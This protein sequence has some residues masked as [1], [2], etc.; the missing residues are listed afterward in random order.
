MNNKSRT[1]RSMKKVLIVAYY[2]PH[3][4]AIGSMRPLGFC[5]Y[6]DR[7]GWQPRVLTTEPISVYPAMGVDK[8]LWAQL[9]KTVRV[10]RVP[11]KNPER[12]LLQVRNKF[13]ELFHNCYSLEGSQLQAVTNGHTLERTEGRK[14]Y[15]NIKQTMIDWLLSFPDPQCYWLRPA[16]RSLS[17]VPRIEY[18]DVVFATGAPWTA[19]FV[20]KA[21]AQRFKVPLVADFRDP[22]TGNVEIR[23]P[24]LFQRATLL[25]RSIYEAA[26]CVI[27]NTDEF[28]TKLLADHPDLEKKFVMITNGFDSDPSNSVVNGWKNQEAASAV[29]VLELCHFGSVYSNRNPFFLLQAVKELVDENRIGSDHLRLRFVGGWEIRGPSCE[30]LARDLEQRQILQRVPPV[31]HD[32]C[33]R[34]M[35]A[36]GILLILQQAFPL[37]IPGKI[38][39]Y[40]AAR[41]PL[42]IIGGEGATAQLVERHN[43]GICCPNKVEDI[44]SLLHRLITDQTCISPPRREEQA[45]FEYRTL[46][47]EL[48]SVFDTVSGGQ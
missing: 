47:G 7:Y 42:L 43:L 27:V 40:I 24:F 46:T 41:R 45:R 37:Q 30:N 25:E 38:Y 17:Q 32:E 18:P 16:I 22:W 31:P 48:A 15:L 14:R 36:A 8:S 44:K 5:R 12:T 35:M 4:A 34:Q 29:P 3:I 33:V 9:P 28:R 26:A 21:L 23:S 11:H 10:D 6:L 13:R 20:G 2:F 39:E 19:L 1:L